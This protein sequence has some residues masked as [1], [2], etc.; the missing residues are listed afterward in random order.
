[1]EVGH[2]MT[3]ELVKN[4]DELVTK[5]FSADFKKS[6]EQLL[7]R[8]ANSYAQAA[9][10]QTA[11]GMVKNFAAALAKFDIDVRVEEID[12]EAQIVVDGRGIRE[13]TTVKHDSRGRIAEFI[14]TTERA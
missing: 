11:C 3:E 14:K 12:G 13:V 5:T 2:Q 4:L 6:L 9:V 8:T 10:D 1:M 7:V